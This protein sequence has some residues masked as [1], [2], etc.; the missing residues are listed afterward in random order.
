[1]KP[2][3]ILCGHYG[4]QDTTRQQ[5]EEQGRVLNE[6]FKKI[7]HDVYDILIVWLPSDC[8]DLTC[9]FPVFQNPED[10]DI[11]VKQIL[12][13]VKQHIEKKDNKW[14]KYIMRF[15]KATRIYGK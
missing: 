12:K 3:I 1:M 5:M 15:F 6:N 2:V 8:F 11:N 13:Q 10:Y 4:W 7:D 9:I 14:F